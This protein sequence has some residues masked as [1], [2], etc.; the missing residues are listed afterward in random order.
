MVEMNTLILYCVLIKRPREKRI[1]IEKEKQSMAI[2]KKRRG[3]EGRPNRNGD[4]EKNTNIW[5]SKRERIL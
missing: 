4:T 2:K 5:K 3:K 1:E